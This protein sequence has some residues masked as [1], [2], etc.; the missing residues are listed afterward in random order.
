MQTGDLGRQ[1]EEFYFDLLPEKCCDQSVDRCCC[2]TLDGCASFA[3]AV[4]EMFCERRWRGRPDDH[5]TADGGHGPPCISGAG[6]PAIASA[7]GSRSGCICQARSPAI[8]ELA[9]KP[10]SYVIE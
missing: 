6:Y 1:R 7:A 2:Q 5:D 4:A 10:G 8:T 9:M 3:V